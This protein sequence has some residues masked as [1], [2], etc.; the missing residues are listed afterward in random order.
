MRPHPRR[1]ITDPTRPEAWGT[2]DRSG[3][4]GNHKNLRWQMEW[5]GTKLINKRVLVFDDQYDT[6]QRQ[7]G[8]LILPPDPVP[9]AN[10]RPE[11][12]PLDEIWPV[13]TEIG[14]EHG[15]IPLYLE[16]STLLNNPEEM[17]AVSL[18]LST[19][20]ATPAA[21]P[22]VVGQSQIGGPDVIA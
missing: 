9:I 18:E 4:V 10:A 20:P 1:T 22:F 7:L 2:D 6:P 21:Q 11:Q 14:T 15:A 16:T 19:I 12:Y 3:F 13:L 17:I 8:T 5:A